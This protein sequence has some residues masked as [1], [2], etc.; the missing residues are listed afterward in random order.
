MSA[1]KIIDCT[2]CPCAPQGVQLYPPYPGEKNTFVELRACRP[3][4]LAQA[5]AENCVDSIIL[6]LAKKYFLEDG[7]LLANMEQNID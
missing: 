7:D 4:P 1:E 5:E 3:C 6:Y 2:K